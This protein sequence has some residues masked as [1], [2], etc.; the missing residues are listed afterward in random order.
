MRFGGD[1]LSAD[2]FGVGNG[3]SLPFQST[4]WRQAEREI[5][6]ALTARARLAILSGVD[7][8][9][10]TT[11]TLALGAALTEEAWR[12]ARWDAGDGNGVAADAPNRDDGSGNEARS[13]DARGGD[14][15]AG[16]GGGDAGAGGEAGSDAAAGL[17][18]AACER[19]GVAPPRVLVGDGRAGG[20]RWRGFGRARALCLIVDAADR[21][22][23]RTLAGLARIA[24]D[25]GAEPPGCCVVVVGSLLLGDRLRR[26][27]ATDAAAPAP[28]EIVLAPLP[29]S[30]IEAYLHH[31]LAQAGASELRL[32]TFDA[33]AQ[34]ALYTR[35]VPRQIN[36]LCLTVL[37]HTRLG[38]GQRIGGV[39][40][41]EAAALSRLGPETMVDD[42]GAFHIVAVDSL[43]DAPA[44]G[45]PGPPV[46]SWPPV[47]PSP[48]PERT[49]RLGIGPAMAMP[50]HADPE[51][52][53]EPRLGCADAELMTILP[54]EPGE[55]AP[56]VFAAA[57]A[58]VTA[59]PAGEPA[60]PSSRAWLR[61]ALAGAAAA[62][63]AIDLG[64]VLVY[65][66]DGG[67]L[68][69]MSA[70]LSAA[71]GSGDA[72]PA[73]AGGPGGGPGGEAVPAPAPGGAPPAG[74][75]VGAGIDV[76]ALVARGRKL[77]ELGDHRAARLVLEHAAA[78]GS[79]AAALM[80]ARSYDPA[81]NPGREAGAAG[82]SAELAAGWYRKAEELERRAAAAEAAAA[83]GGGERP[84]PQAPAPAGSAAG[85]LAGRGPGA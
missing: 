45:F 38:R 62:V 6:A 10:K 50:E 65:G 52:A 59:A 47:N 8:V 84:R 33:I 19:A 26:L 51:A 56:R 64:L 22:S 67:R 57:P 40:I 21:L 48:P 63:L 73:P 55:A 13:D 42:S 82:W 23:D 36:R 12:V 79:A 41:D 70:R 4:P 46:Q 28:V 39:T 5:R 15:D 3:P 68:G 44:P 35:G 11:L 17:V 54:P 76:E 60:E 27:C 29:A 71:L 37:E 83:G 49:A 32:F 66:L 77:F 9:G 53:A 58:T 31:R 18:L 72:A 16:D 25:A 1:G 20:R 24:A 80:L 69:G 61:P 14:H 85:G 43:D 7:G 2:A 78:R 81:V 74:G 75:A 34:I 30:E